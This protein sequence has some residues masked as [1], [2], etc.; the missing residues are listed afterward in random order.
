[1]SG[2]GVESQTLDDFGKSLHLM[3]SDKEHLRSLFVAVQNGDM[4]VLARMGIKDA[5]LGDVK[6][7]LEKLIKTGFLD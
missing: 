6:F 2:N 3:G 7:F 5:E 4:G 1:M